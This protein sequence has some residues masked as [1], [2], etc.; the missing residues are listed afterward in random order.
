VTG[1][2]KERNLTVLRIVVF[3]IYIALVF[4]TAG[5]LRWLNLWIFLGFYAVATTGFMLWLRK[6]HPGLLKERMSNKPDAKRW[7]KVVVQSFTTCIVAVFIVAALDAGRFHWSRVPPAVQ[8]TAFAA[9]ALAWAIVV[10]AARENAFLS[11][12]VRIQTDRG[13]RVCTTGPYRFIRHPM[14]LADIFICLGIP[15]FLG[16]LWALIPAALAVAL[17]VL[18]TALEDRTLRNELPGYAEY[19]AAVRRRLIPGFW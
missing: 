13:H 5:S 6:R 8:W 11:S 18:R 16:S 10:W 14:Y 7:D 19:A 17:F 4:F 9:L 12:Y 15:L 3:L 2:L 1:R